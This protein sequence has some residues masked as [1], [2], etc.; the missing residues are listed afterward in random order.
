M[1]RFYKSVKPSSNKAQVLHTENKTAAPTPPK[2]SK[3]HSEQKDSGE[4]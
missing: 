2:K 1:A 3:E 4:S